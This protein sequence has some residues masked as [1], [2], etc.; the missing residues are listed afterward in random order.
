MF[1]SLAIH[2]G[3]Q[4]HQNDCHLLVN[5]TL[6]TNEGVAY[7]SDEVLAIEVSTAIEGTN[8]VIRETEVL[9]DYNNAGTTTVHRGTLYIY[10]NL[11]DTGT[12][13]GEID[14]GPVR[15]GGRGGGGAAPQLTRRNQVMV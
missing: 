4:L 14:T 6:A 3:G 9:G 10:G 13:A 2:G 7:L 5:G 12:M 15:D 11:T 1:S 8:R